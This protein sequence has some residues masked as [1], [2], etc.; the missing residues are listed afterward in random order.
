MVEFLH[1]RRWEKI[2]RINVYWGV[3]KVCVGSIRL[4]GIETFCLL[5]YWA[6]NLYR[7]WTISSLYAYFLC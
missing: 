2:N 7:F 4:G 3:V 6:Q 5:K 1:V